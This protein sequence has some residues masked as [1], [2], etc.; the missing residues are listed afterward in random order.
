M[1]SIAKPL[2][3]NYRF[4]QMIYLN[5]HVYPSIHYPK[6]VIGIKTKINVLIK[7]PI[8]VNHTMV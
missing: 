6:I 7:L 1:E 8:I 4:V 2:I 3:Q 5:N